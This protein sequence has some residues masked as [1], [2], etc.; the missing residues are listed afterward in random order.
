MEYDPVNISQDSD[1]ADAAQ[2]MAM[3]RISGLPVVNS[4]DTLV[5]IITK[6]DIVKAMAANS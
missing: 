2:I 6:T 5:G 3:N 1:L 4:N